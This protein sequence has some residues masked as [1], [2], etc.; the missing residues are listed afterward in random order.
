MSLPTPQDP[1]NP[2]VYPNGQEWKPSMKP[3]NFGNL[4][5]DP[6]T[7]L[8]YKKPILKLKA[9]NKIIDVVAER[10]RQ[11]TILLNKK[12]QLFENKLNDFIE[13]NEIER[14]YRKQIEQLQKLKAFF[15]NTVFTPL[16]EIVEP[17][18][19]QEYTNRFL[20]RDPDVASFD[21]ETQ[22]IMEN[23]QGIQQV[24]SENENL[25]TEITQLR[26][27]VEKL[28]LQRAG[29]ANTERDIEE[30]TE[31]SNELDELNKIELV[32]QDPPD[33]DDLNEMTDVEL[34]KEVQEQEELESS[35]QQ[36][37]ELR[38][39]ARMTKEEK[40]QQREKQEEKREDTFNEI[41]TLEKRADA[42]P[43]NYKSII[44]KATN[45]SEARKIIET[46]ER[47]RSGYTRKSYMKQ[48]KPVQL[49]RAEMLL[50]KAVDII[51]EQPKL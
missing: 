5:A 40:E 19:K 18:A 45:A 41:S 36:L 3:A 1:L 13:E 10:Q 37:Q 26:S 16:Y 25:M 15:N 29:E 30:I 14:E 28:L 46:V 23:A 17:N 9:Y 43:E 47:L 34:T 44:R 6:P 42:L 33:T 31:L 51:K 49:E 20:K 4:N 11:R 39:R 12:A 35:K 32:R 21:S 27:E 7:N 50:M 48:G 8:N 38:K 24:Q 2:F 22:T